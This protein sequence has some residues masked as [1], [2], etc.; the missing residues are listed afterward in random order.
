MPPTSATFADFA[1]GCADGEDHAN[2]V[3]NS[4]EAISRIMADTG[5]ALIGLEKVTRAP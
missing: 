5:I 4:V 3:S 1:A 2:A